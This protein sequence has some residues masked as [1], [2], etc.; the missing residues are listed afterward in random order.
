MHNFRNN[1]SRFQKEPEIRNLIFLRSRNEIDR[2]KDRVYEDPSNHQVAFEHEDE[3]DSNGRVHEDERDSNGR[4]HEDE[5]DSNGRVHED[6]RDSNGR[7]H[8]DERDSNGR[9]HEDERDSNGRV[10]ET[11]DL[12]NENDTEQELRT[13]IRVEDK[14]LENI[15]NQRYGTLY[16]VRVASKR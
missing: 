2:Q 3:R 13:V 10:H 8:E 14:E 5:R 6:E 1:A 11:N 16:N 12:I 9:V 15:F 4:V 7:V